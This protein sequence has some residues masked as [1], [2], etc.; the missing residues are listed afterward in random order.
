M[1][2]EAY[3]QALATVPRDMEAADALERIYTRLADYT[4]LVLLLQRKVDM[5]DVAA[6]K[7]ELCVRAAQIWEEVLDTPEKAIEAYR[8]ALA[9]DDADLPVLDSLERLFV[10]LERWSD[11]KDVYAKQAD[12]TTD[13]SQK[14]Q[15]LF[16]LGQVYDRE[17][18]DPARAIETYS[19]AGHRSRRR[20]GLAGARSPVRRDRALVRSALRARAT[21]RAAPARLPRWCRCAIASASCGARS[22]T[23]RLGP[24]RPTGGSWRWIPSYDPTLRAIEGMMQRGEEPIA[25][26]EVL[27]PIYESA[28]DWDKVAGTYEVMKQHA[29]PGVALICWASSP[30]STRGAWRIST[31]PSMPTCAPC[32]WIRRTPRSSRTSTAWPKPAGVGPS[33]P[34]PSRLISSAIMDSQLQ[35]EMLLRL[36]R[37]YEEETR[38]VD[39]AIATFKRVAEAE[40][41]R[42]DGLVALDRLYT[43]TERWQDL[44]EIVRREIR[45]ADTEDQIVSLTYRLAQILEVALADLPKAV[46]AYQEILGIAPQH[47]ETRA[48]LERLMA[49]G[50]MQ[51]EIAQ[52][53]EPLYRVGE[54]WEK[55]VRVYQVELA[56]DPSRRSGSVSCAAWPTS[57]KASS[58]TRSPRSIGG[59]ARSSRRRR[60]SKRST[61]RCAWLAPPTSGKPTSRP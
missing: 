16:V 47:E 42:K 3:Q 29:G 50:T 56:S 35:V 41:D 14:K 40:P 22:S 28:G 4:N 34:P 53:L 44:A 7:R 48:T 21:D 32:A 61:R 24:S 59:P 37:V 55:L 6:E 12:L 15:R 49:G 60:P 38:E 9:L 8:Q 33:L 11:L 23:M 5:T 43:M 57:P 36:A 26:A 58:S 31:P 19:G 27:Q 10:R 39:K 51:R 17:L 18:K 1:A 46:E 30:A 20:R 52:V 54:E 13:P 25:A 45:L 2:A